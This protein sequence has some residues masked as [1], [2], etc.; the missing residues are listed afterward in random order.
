MLNSTSVKLRLIVSAAS[1]VLRAVISFFTGVYIARY[2][3]PAGYGEMAFLLGSFV[4][5]RALL[6]LG[7]SSAFFT[8]LSRQAR[9]KLFFA[10]YFSWLAVQ[11]FIALVLLWLVIPTNLLAEIWLGYDREV[12]I[13]A[14]VSTFM[15]QQVWQMVGHCGEARRK[16]IRVQLMNITVALVYFAVIVLTATYS[17][18][19]VQKIFVILIG[20]YAVATA[21]AYQVLRENQPIEP[22]PEQTVKEICLS[23][24]DYCKP[25]LVLAIV[26][27]AYEFADKW[28]LQK[29]GG[30]AQQ[31][32]FQIASQFSAVS[33]LATTSI[34]NVFWQELASAWERQ[35]RARAAVLYQKV[36][37]C[38]VM[39]AAS[40]SGLL[41]PWSEEIVNIL[42]GAQYAGA[43]PTFAIMLFYPIHQSMGQINGAMFL[44][45]GKTRIYMYISIA[46]MLAATPVSYVMLANTTSGF[47]AG[48]GLGALGMAIKMVVIGMI[49]VNIQAWM[50]A[51]IGGWK[52]DW[53]FQLVGIPLMIIL[54]LA[55]RAIVEIPWN[56]GDLG[57][58]ELILPVIVGTVLYILML[59]TAFWRMPWLVGLNQS[60]VRKIFKCA[61]VKS[62]MNK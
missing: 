16:T 11:F 45:S 41:F 21:S 55:A 24:W 39:L 25:L 13:L 28:M 50:M 18:L 4:A 23:Y 52:F 30:A 10:L 57:G 12:V 51:K 29:Y 54:G 20:L 35:D 32:Y 31:G 33:L 1:N 8:F 56:L 44:A 49:S 53:L 5:I 27:F 61:T 62:P 36:C 59:M 42:L 60:D 46:V 48:L 38:M 17:Q 37:R 40:V 7:S 58:T 3:S 6:D 2:L 47:I 43:W 22:I 14:F 19:T 26:S 15:Q 34:L 9:G